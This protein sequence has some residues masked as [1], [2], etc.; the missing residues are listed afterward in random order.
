MIK[1]HHL[2]MG[3]RIREARRDAGF[4]NVESF[5]LALGVSR[6]TIDRWENDQFTPA[7][8]RLIEI[9]KLTGKPVTYFMS[10]LHNGE[11]T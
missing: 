9:A 11:A 10:G 2:T 7:V 3:R 5:A 8:I 6:R 4:S 1:T